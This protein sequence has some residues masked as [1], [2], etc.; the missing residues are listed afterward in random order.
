MSQHLKQIAEDTVACA[1][2]RAYT[3]PIKGVVKLARDGRPWGPRPQT[4]N[5]ILNVGHVPGPP[6][7]MT[8][9]NHTTLEGLFWLHQ[10]DPDETPCVLNFASGKNPGGGF[11]RGTQAQEE[12]LARASTLYLSLKG[13]PHY[14]WNRKCGTAAYQDTMIYSPDLVFKDDG[15]RLL[16][17]PVPAAF[18][19]AAAPNR[20]AMRQHGEGLSV[21]PKI[22]VHRALMILSIAAARGHKRLIMGAWGCGVFHN[23]LD[24]VIAAFKQALDT[25]GGHFTHVH[26]A[27][28]DGPQGLTYE[29]F[30]LAFGS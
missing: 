24:D 6:K 21:I 14:Q 18:I 29:C 2:R 28:L 20:G 5:T 16:E 1:E 8:V 17:E 13:S 7:K 22:L 15:G 25:L 12:S 30:R 27:V 26:F 3:H 19:T 4:F 10:L 11:L 9:E 23:E